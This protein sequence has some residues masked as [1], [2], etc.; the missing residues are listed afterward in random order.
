M[1]EMTNE[2]DINKEF[3]VSSNFP[4]K[5]YVKWL[6]HT[7]AQL[8]MSK[9]NIKDGLVLREVEDGIKRRSSI[10]RSIYDEAFFYN[11]MDLFFA[12]EMELVEKSCSREVLKLCVLQMQNL[13][14]L[15]KD[16]YQDFPEYYQMKCKINDAIIE[17][18]L[19]E[20]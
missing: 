17:S 16:I 11:I 10:I 20:R 6:Q 18:I 1:Q 15:K 8:E 14:G 5:E 9:K 4:S 13:K 2:K 12:G 7:I 3:K 19:G